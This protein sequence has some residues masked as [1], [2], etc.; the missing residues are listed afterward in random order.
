MYTK[1]PGIHIENGILYDIEW[2]LTNPNK[3]KPMCGCHYYIFVPIL[4]TPPL[5]LFL[6]L[7][8]PFLF[9]HL[10]S[11]WV[12]IHVKCTRLCES[13]L[14]PS[15]LR[16]TNCWHVSSIWIC[17]RICGTL[18]EVCRFYF[19]FL[20]STLANAQF[21]IWRNCVSALIRGSSCSN[22]IWFLLIIFLHNNLGLVPSSSSSSSSHVRAFIR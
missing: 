16:I 7:F 22:I 17:Q 6:F 4:F 13:S 12:C 15:I 9:F 18:S 2:K 8:F 10:A 19:C 20:R 5:L 14:R 11:V 21:E 3:S 1:P